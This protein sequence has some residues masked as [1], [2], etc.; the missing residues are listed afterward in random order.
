MFF[1]WF[2]SQSKQN[3]QTPEHSARQPN[4]LAI[5][6]EGPSQIGHYFRPGYATSTGSGKF[7]EPTDA[8][9]PPVIRPDGKVHEWTMR[10]D[11]NGADGRGRITV[12]LDGEATSLDLAPGEKQQGATFDR[13]GLFNLQAGGHHVRISFDDLTFSTRAPKRPQG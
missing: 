3:K 7:G 12:T 13:F 9:S 8:H 10:Y 4:Y 11:P 6:I 2:D 5:L 1:G